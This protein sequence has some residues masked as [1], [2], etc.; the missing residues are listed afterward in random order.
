M[1]C[2]LSA[3]MSDLHMQS[4]WRR[5]SGD[6]AYAAWPLPKRADPCCHLV[7]IS[8]LLSTDSGLA[9]M[10]T[11]IP[12]DIR[13]WARTPGYFD[14][15]KSSSD[16]NIDE[17]CGSCGAISTYQYVDTLRA[18]R[19]YTS[20]S[21]TLHT[22]SECF[23]PSVKVRG[24]LA[25]WSNHIPSKNSQLMLRAVEIQPLLGSDLSRRR[26]VKGV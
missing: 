15:F 24:E 17:S 11:I 6:N 4:G 8:R 19:K 9:G 13:L 26:R 18:W 12:S 23:R 16:Y 20:V 5:E 21:C 1:L 10:P 7:C 2:C 14:S 3:E 25:I 22:D